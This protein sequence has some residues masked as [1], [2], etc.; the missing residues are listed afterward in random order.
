MSVPWRG[1]EVF[2]VLAALVIVS[3]AIGQF[4]GVIQ[5]WVNTQTN[6]PTSSFIIFF[7]L[8]A[9]AQATVL[10]GLVIYY[11]RQRYKLPW[12]FL[13]LSP[14][15]ISR[16]L[17]AG[18]GG[19]VILFFSVILIS[20]GLSWLMPQPTEPQPY[21]DILLAA[22]DWR[23]LALV[24]A[25]GSILAP[26]SEEFYFRGFLFPYLR[27]R[28]GVTFGMWGSAAIFGALHLDPW[29]FIPLTLGGFGLAFIYQRT[30]SLFASILAHSVWNT[31]MSVLVLIG[32]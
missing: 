21:V 28:L 18:L 31:I 4:G 13:G 11:V 27:E 29:R 14:C 24:M 23:Q 32:S 1:R 17:A 19:G 6:D 5:S 25:V 30:G 10:I 22:Q 9:M 8:A 26:L 2:L 7:I 15:S 3:R 20:L 12:L 16:V